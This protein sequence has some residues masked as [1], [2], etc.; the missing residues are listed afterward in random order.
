MASARR[1]LLLLAG[2]IALPSL[3]L[4]QDFA[5]RGFKLGPTSPR[6]ASPEDLAAGKEKRADQQE[7]CRA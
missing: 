1:W 2:T 4:A 5:A 7:D 6:Q 3:A